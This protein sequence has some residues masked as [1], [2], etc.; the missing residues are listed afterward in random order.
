MSLRRAGG[1]QPAR[2]AG[3]ARVRR[4]Y[5]A[6]IRGGHTYAAGDAARGPTSAAR[7]AGPALPLPPGRPR[8]PPRRG[9]A[10]ETDVARVWRRSSC[11]P[12]SSAGCAPLALVGSGPGQ[13]VPRL[14][15]RQAQYKGVGVFVPELNETFGFIPSIKSRYGDRRQTRRVAVGAAR[16]ARARAR[17]GCLRRAGSRPALRGLGSPAQSHC[18]ARVPPGSKGVRCVWKDF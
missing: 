12:C 4:A 9:R 13:L 3:S 16:R 2:T 1:C 6:G 11:A 15:S 7:R 14:S 8:R 17:P 5:A 10:R 18:P